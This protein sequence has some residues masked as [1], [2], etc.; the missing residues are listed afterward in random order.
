MKLA[1]VAILVIA[2]KPTTPI[3]NVVP[4]HKEQP[5]TAQGAVPAEELPQIPEPQ[6]KA[7]PEP[8]VVT[9][10]AEPTVVTQ[11]GNCESYRPLVAQYD[12]NVDVAMNVMRVESGCNPNAANLKDNHQVCIGSYGLFQISCH[13]GKIFD[14]AA[15]VAAAYSKYSARGWQPWSFTTC[16]KI[17]CY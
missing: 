12:W 15:N 1:A 8:A 11:P 10:K 16:K 7:E 17:A 3:N 4:V 5:V 2:L 6:A 9:V 14:P 13:G